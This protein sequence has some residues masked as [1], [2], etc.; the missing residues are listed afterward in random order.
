MAQLTSFRT[1]IELWDTREA[2]AAEVGARP[3]AVSKWWQRDSLPADWWAAVLRTK[4]AKAAGIDAAK[5]T[6][7]AAR[8]PTTRS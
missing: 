7:L 4:R 6:A 2:M 1:I 3:Q 5:L 8:Q